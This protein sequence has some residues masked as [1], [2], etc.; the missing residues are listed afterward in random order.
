MIDARQ[1][2][3]VEGVQGEQPWGYPRTVEAWLC[4]LVAGRTTWHKLPATGE[5]VIGSDTSADLQVEALGVAGR[6]AVVRCF[7]MQTV[8]EDLGSGLSTKLNGLRLE[9]PTVL[10]Q[11][12]WILIGTAL[13]GLRVLLPTWVGTRRLLDR[14]DFLV[15]TQ[16]EQDRCE[17]YG[18]TAAVVSI[19]FDPPPAPG[20]E[21]SQLFEFFRRQVRRMD[22]VGMLG[23]ATFGVLLP[24]VGREGALVWVRRLEKAARD[25]GRSVSVDIVIH[26]DDK[27][28]ATSAAEG[29]AGE[30]ASLPAPVAR[31][32]VSS[33]AVVL[34]SEVMKQV[35][36]L[37]DRAAASTIS[38]LLLGETGV[39]KEV[40]ASAIH[41]RSA[42]S[43]RPLVPVNCAAL[44]DSLIEGELFGVERGA[45]TG[46]DRPRAGL[47]EQAAGGTLLL[48]EVGDIPP[49]LQPKLLRAIQDKCI[50]RLG[51]TVSRPVD[52]RL[53]AA[54]NRNLE[55]MVAEGTFRE[56][57]YYRLSAF[58][59]AIPPLRNRRDDIP[60]LVMVALREAA[61]VMQRP[62]PEVSEAVM[63]K[64][65]SHPWPGNVRQLFNVVERALVLE[66][67]LMLHEQ[68]FP[69]LFDLASPPSAPPTPRTLTPRPSA[70]G[71]EV[72][73]P[74]APSVTFS[75]SEPPSSVRFDS[76]VMEM[77]R[78][79][80]LD[81]LERCDG[82]QT[83]AAEL[84]AMPRRTF[85]YKLKRHGIRRGAN[86]E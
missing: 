9:E 15:R 84:L 12:D 24:E 49:A 27:R 25:L 66:D 51:S 83:R 3:G 53:V 23:G 56:D 11:G 46:S 44:P 57:L 72:P 82:N 1:Q 8:V 5:L 54:T 59:I 2:Q 80:L 68:A 41:A 79:L 18:R 35:Y 63:A 4:C 20:E 22:V 74:Q 26:P 36:A 40:I 47:I 17:R 62:V 30:A 43:A 61:A 71:A 55:S 7:P 32:A 76:A 10:R 34:E 77:E 39:G 69:Q 19:V 16:E 85:V 60:G 42:R 29:G 6:H 81:A 14:D 37:V 21:A 70:V 28:E 67:S 78:R 48:D 75:P 31:V 52:F 58:T 33:R 73:L 38:V 64:L 45:F 65:Q 50:R 13:I 86:H